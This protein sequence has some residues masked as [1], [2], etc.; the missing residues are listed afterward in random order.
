MCGIAGI[1]RFNNKNEPNDFKLVEEAL[2]TMKLRGPDNSKVTQHQ[3]CTLGHVRLSIIDTSENANQPFEFNNNQLVF[4]GEIFNYKELKQNLKK[5]FNFKTESDTEV[6][7]YSLLSKPITEALNSL[8]GFFAFS[9]FN[10]N[11]NEL[12]VARDRY[13]IKP[14]YYYADKEKFCFASELKGLIKLGVKKELN[15]EALETYLHLNYIPA[16]LTIFK[17]V[18]KLIPGNYIVL[19]ENNEI[20][21]KNYYKLEESF[22][23]LS[24]IN[25]YSKAQ[26]QFRNILNNSVQKRLVSDVPLG[27]FL[28]GGIDSSV[29]T[30]IAAKE[31]KNL[32]TFSIGFKDEPFFDET[33]Y[34][35]LVSKKHKT[36][37]TVFKLSN[38]DLY[39]HLFDVLDYIDEPF[40][41]SSAL[42]VFILSKETRKKVTVALSGDGADELL[43]GYNKHRGE[44]LSRKYKFA[45]PFFKGIKPITQLVPQSRNSK[46]L[47]KARQANK[48]LETTLLNTQERYWRLAGFT[49]NKTKSL[50]LP[51]FN[52][53]INKANWLSVIN[54]NDFNTFL[55]TDQKLVLEGDMLVK[56][57][58]MSM[59]NSLEIRVP[60][61]D[62]RLVDF[63][64][65]IP[66]QFKIDNNRRKKILIDSCKDLLPVEL[67]NRKKQ[68]F[69]VPLL[70]WFKTDLKSLIT[71]DLLSEQNIKEQGIFNYNEIKSLLNQLF[72]SSP[73]DAVARVWGLIVFQYWYKKYFIND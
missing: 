73:G 7:A 68:G 6:L 56:A 64:N 20:G 70:K 17:N 11:N 2:K 35:E 61:L 54:E 62:Y 69:E 33:E 19:T 48:F 4:N 16:P 21:I 72:S 34:A 36:N 29:I 30:G 57:D 26:E 52:N 23:Q 49:T 42:N 1:W 55:L 32:N 40:A 39:Q 8:N 24:P 58:R 59:A 38:N 47:N 44:W 13:G 10:F 12:T 45:T 65:S 50:L 53:T 41:D 15:T 5:D 22:K 71:D 37:H 60:F 9:Y 43:A 51:K 3:N 18:Y 46:I 31:V 66:A 28:S 63:T 67:F 25:D 14:L 27:C